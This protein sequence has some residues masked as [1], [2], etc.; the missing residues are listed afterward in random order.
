MKKNNN[1]IYITPVSATQI[2][3]TNLGF[4]IISYY[5]S[6][7]GNSLREFSPVCELAELLVLLF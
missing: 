1:R 7:M 5:G 4:F 3:K 2:R 6:G